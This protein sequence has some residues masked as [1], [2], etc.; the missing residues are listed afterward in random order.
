MNDFDAFFNQSVLTRSLFLHFQVFAERT[1]D[2]DRARIERTAATFLGDM[3]NC[4]RLSLFLEICKLLDPPKD[5]NGNENLSVF[6]MLDQFDLSKSIDP[7][8]LAETRSRFENFRKHL[9]PA[10]HKLIAHHDRKAILKGDALGHAPQNDWDQFWQ[11]LDLIIDAL[12]RMIR[13]QPQR[14]LEV[15][16]LTDADN[17]LTA[18][19]KAEALD[20]LIDDHHADAMKALAEI[21]N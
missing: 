2:A 3:V 16:G 6:Y 14:L 18:L 11:D 17:I 21:E 4:L 5:R 15:G 7:K 9:Q 12:S 10:R 20:R 19:K 8:V 13:K 1:T